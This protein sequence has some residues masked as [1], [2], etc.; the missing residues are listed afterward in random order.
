MY[1]YEGVVS[2]HCEEDIAKEIRY[3]LNVI[4]SIMNVC[5]YVSLW[6]HLFMCVYIWLVLVMLL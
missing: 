1:Y 5:V 4:L 2:K 6:L 3:V